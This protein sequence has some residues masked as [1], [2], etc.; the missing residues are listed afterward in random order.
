[1]ISMTKRELYSLFGGPIAYIVIALFLLFSGMLFFPTFFI[2]DQA[3]MRGFFQLLP[4]LFSFFVPAIT[5]RSFAEERSKGTFEALVSFPV[6]SGKIVLS[7]FFAAVIFIA[8]MLAPTLLYVVLISLV[9]DPDPGPIIGGYV[10]ALLL[11]AAYAAV[12]LFASSM[13]SNQIVAFI[14]TAAI[15]LLFTFFDQMLVLVP[16]ALVNILEFLGTQYHFKTISRGLLD[17]R[18]L[19]YLISLTAVFLLFTVKAVKER[20]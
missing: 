6:S 13:T 2:Y 16:A 5:M 18:S 15:A 3:E 1:M 10:G 14:V 11:G 12:G 8:V 19:I 20:R 4:I 9:G 17:S 7:K